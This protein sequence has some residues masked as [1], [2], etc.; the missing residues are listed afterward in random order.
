MAELAEQHA[1][2]DQEAISEAPALLR[3]LYAD[4]EHTAEHLALWSVMRFAGRA[5]S[6]V[7][8]IQRAHVAAEPDVQQ[9]A[10]VHRQTRVSMTEGAVVGGPFIVLIPVAFCAALLAQA[11][12]VLALAVLAGHAADDE[13]RVAELLV[14]QRVY[15]SEHE[16]QAELKRVKRDLNPRPDARLPR[17]TRWLTIKRMA[18]LLGLLG[19]EEK[20]PS[21]IRTVLQ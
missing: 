10:V 1:A 18:L 17:G 5:T 21:L 14:L 2:A 13:T 16:A 15:P 3:V 6:A 9:R 19:S 7:E 8:K 20:R 12:M 11:Q 4:P